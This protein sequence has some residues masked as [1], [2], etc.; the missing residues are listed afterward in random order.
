MKH[1]IL[2]GT[3]DTVREQ[4]DKIEIDWSIEVVSTAMVCKPTGVI[5]YTIVIK[6]KRPKR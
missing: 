5:I 3:I 4:L 2:T 1:K 6:I